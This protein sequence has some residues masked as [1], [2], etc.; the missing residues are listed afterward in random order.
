MTGVFPVIVGSDN[1]CCD[2]MLMVF[3]NSMSCAVWVFGFVAPMIATLIVYGPGLSKI[4]PLIIGML[5]DDDSSALGTTG[6]LLPSYFVQRQTSFSV[7]SDF[8]CTLTV[9]SPSLS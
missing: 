6:S 8:G 4:G 5:V 1:V 7:H 9:S 3:S 2:A